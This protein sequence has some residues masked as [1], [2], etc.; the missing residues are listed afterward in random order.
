MAASGHSPLTRC[1]K[2]GKTLYVQDDSAHTSP[3]AQQYCC[4][5]RMTM[6][7][8]QGLA[9]MYVL[10][11][12]TLNCMPLCVQAVTDQRSGGSAT[13]VSSCPHQLYAKVREAWV[14]LAMPRAM[15]VPPTAPV[16][17]CRLL[18]SNARTARFQAEYFTSKS[19]GREVAGAGMATGVPLKRTGPGRP[20]ATM[21]DCGGWSGKTMG[22]AV[23]VPPTGTPHGLVVTTTTRSFW[24]CRCQGL[25]HVG[26]EAMGGGKGSRRVN[27][28]GTCFL[29][30]PDL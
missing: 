20:S 12:M 19:A 14:Q 11:S 15:T 21:P 17:N 18:K 23:G 30:V 10:S 8:R 4:R 29:P 9:E 28:E 24:H 27:T 2:Q 22:T 13:H 7:S 25:Q 6:L 26:K 16:H 1:A 3:G 5:P